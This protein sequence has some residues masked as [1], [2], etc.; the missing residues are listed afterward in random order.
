MS[1]EQ[2]KINLNQ[3]LWALVVSLLTLG[4]AEYYCLKTLFWFGVILSGLSTLSLVFTLF[5]Y[6]I[7]YV[8]NKWK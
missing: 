7:N 2:F 4:A 5:A 3:N 6:T 8:K 1:T